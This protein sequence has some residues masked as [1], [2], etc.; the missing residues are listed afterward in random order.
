MRAYAGTCVAAEQENTLFAIQ[1]ELVHQF[2][3]FR[4]QVGVRLPS[5]ALPGNVAITVFLLV[6]I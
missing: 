5:M 6:P 1:M 4:F 3:L 2:L